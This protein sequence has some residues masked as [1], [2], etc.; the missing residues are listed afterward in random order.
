MTTLV[1]LGVLYLT[2]RVGHTGAEAVW[3]DLATR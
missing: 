1:A 2:F 3:G